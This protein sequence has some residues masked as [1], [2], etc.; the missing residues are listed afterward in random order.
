MDTPSAP[1][2]SLNTKSWHETCR[3]AHFSVRPRRS[4]FSVPTAA[5][6]RHRVERPSRMAAAWRPPEGLVLDGREHGGRRC[7]AGGE[8]AIITA[9]DFLLHFPCPLQR[10]GSGSG[11]AIKNRAFGLI[12]K[13][14]PAHKPAMAAI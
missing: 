14:D 13:P 4:H 8:K 3:T 12:R 10:L 7:H 5:Q 6:L 1:S 2:F 9:W 11:N